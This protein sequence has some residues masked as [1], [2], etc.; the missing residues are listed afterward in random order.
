MRIQNIKLRNFRNHQDT[1]LDFDGET[2]LIIGKNGAG[3][4]NLLEAIHLLATTKSLHSKYDKEMISHDKK[5]ARIDANINPNGDKQKLE[6]LITKSD[7]FENASS[8]KVKLDKVARS[9][10]N[11][12]GTLNTVLFTPHDVELFTASP[13]I[14]RKY[15][16]ALFFQI[17]KKYKRATSQ[18]TKAVRQRNKILEQIRDFGTGK[19]QLEYWD[20]KVIETGTIIQ[21]SRDDYF[22]FVQK[23]INTHI[24]TLSS[25]DTTC[26]I[27][28]N[29]SEINPDALKE[30]QDTEIRA[31][32]T[33]IGPHRDD[34]SINY[35]NHDIARY[36]SRGQKRTTILAL[37]LCE[38]DFI[39]K[40]LDRRPILLL[41]D[42]FS[43]LDEGHKDAV[44]NS[45]DL[46]QT[47]ITSAEPI[48]MGKAIHLINI[49]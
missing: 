24:D 36:G 14:R 44:T 33:L 40:Y 26:E 31:G 10:N 4:T 11:F 18:Y 7:K 16:D 49:G 5:F 37:K 20:E 32:R 15:L 22:D 39:N 45:F 47:I 28:Y 17:D 30:S 38:I 43:E 29:K 34:F 8:K 42:I 9:L 12:A 46:Q 27:I 23:I 6:L 1:K 48:N 3:K 25:E 35:N 13:S 41:D 21:N 19:N 2:T